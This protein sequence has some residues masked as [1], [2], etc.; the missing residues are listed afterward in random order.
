MLK[1]LKWLGIGIAGLLLLVVIL[2]GS[3]FLVGR[4]RANTAPEVATKP[5]TVAANDTA[6]IARGRHI[7]EAIT[8]CEACHGPDLGGKA[9]PIPAILTSM[10]APNL[11]RGQGGVGATYTLAD[12]DR[13]IRHGIGKDGRRL[14]IM[15]AEAY[16]YLNDSDAAALIAYL[17][18]L[19]PV[20]RSFAPRKVGLAGGAMLGAGMMPTPYDMIAHDSVGARPVVAPGVTV[21]YGGYLANSAGCKVCHGFDFRGERKGAGP[22]LGPSLVAFVANNSAEAFRNTLRTGTTPSGRA[23]DAEQMPWTSYRNMTDD[24]IEAVRLYIRSTFTK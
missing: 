18:T 6:A 11:T 10:A 8:G 21:E 17:Q 12:W 22:P 3:L 4:S 14:L 5:V 19:A 13:A 9:F 1:V 7:A 2:A 15:P 23:L 20:D 24:E 16:N